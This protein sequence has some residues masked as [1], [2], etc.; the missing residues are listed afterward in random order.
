MTP[1]DFVECIRREILEANL[2]LYCQTLERSLSEPKISDELWRGTGD[3]Y[4]SLDTDHRRQMIGT[5][6]QVMV[7]TLSNV[8]GVLD[9]S[10]LLER[11]RDYFHLTYGTAPTELNGELQDPFLSTES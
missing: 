7:A 8:L 2:E 10:S 11:H 3:L 9:G 5:I 1:Q 6:R 4:R